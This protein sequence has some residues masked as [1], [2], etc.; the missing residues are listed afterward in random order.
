MG[1]DDVEL[2]PGFGRASSCKLIVRMLWIAPY[3]ICGDKM[4][5][6]SIHMIAAFES[7]VH[8]IMGA[9]L[10]WLWPA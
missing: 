8:N 1:S 4:R 10:F 5:D 2:V 9:A 7:A 3:P 6:V